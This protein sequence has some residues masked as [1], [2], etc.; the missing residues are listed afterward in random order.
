M[1][2]KTTTTVVIVLAVVVIA[3]G[4]Y[5]GFNKWRQQRLANQ[6]LTEMYGVGAGDV[7]KLTGGITGKMAADIAEEAAKQDAADKKAA[8]EEAAKTPEDRFNETKEVALT[9]S[10]ASVVKDNIEPIL[11]TVF[12]KVKPVLFSG[13]YMGQE[14]S[15]LASFKI[16]SVPTSEDF[17]KL[18]EEFTSDGY[19]VVMNSV[20]ADSGNLMLQK[21]DITISIS[22]E[23]P[24][25]QEIGVLYVKEAAS[26]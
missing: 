24:E 10:T 17:N 5:Y 15:F 13:G 20:T 3:G 7:S 6:I 23:S 21:D 8:E 14:G 26:E 1:D 16:P 18:T 12:G 19:K 22:Y 25:D 4:V 11:T 2:K 9:G